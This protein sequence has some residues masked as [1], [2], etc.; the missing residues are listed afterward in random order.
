MLIKIAICDDCKTDRNHLK[1]LLENYEMHYQ[2]DFEITEYSSAEGLLI[3]LNNTHTFQVLLLDIEIKDA[4]GIELGK[5]IRS[6][7]HFYSPIIFVS[8]YPQY[9]QQSM[10]V[11]P[12]YYLEK[13]VSEK[14]FN[15]IFT[16]LIKELCSSDHY[17]TLVQTDLSEEM[18][19]ISDICYIHTVNSKQRKLELHLNDRYLT[20]S[21]IISDWT[22][23]L[24]AYGFYMCN[25]T[26]LINIAH[27][28]YIKNKTVYL[29]NGSCFEASRS[30][31][32]ILKDTYLNQI[33][34]QNPPL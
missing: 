12:F 26:T 23:K 32:K 7:L 34:K 21:G 29:T 20:I 5:K 3:A 31:L 18:I 28:H 1:N 27:L 10:L 15:Y 11:K 4:N 17:L 30:N 13:P 8:S 33:I 2:V 14:T 25:R 24:S 22:D 6:E 16:E 9:M 19:H